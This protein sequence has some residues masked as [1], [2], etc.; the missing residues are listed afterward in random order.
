MIPKFTFR[1]A[2]ILF[3]VTAAF[4]PF[5]RGEAEPAPEPAAATKV[6]SVTTNALAEYKAKEGRGMVALGTSLME[7]KDFKDAE[8]AFRQVLSSRDYQAVHRDAL[9]GIARVY[10]M[11]G[12]LTKAAAIYQKFIKEFSEDPRI[13]DAMLDLGRTLRS[14]GA[15]K[16]AVNSFYNVINSSLK[17]PAD[18]FAHYELLAKTA[19]FEIAETHFEAGNYVDAAKFFSRL[20]LLD[21]APAD[22][23]RAHFKSACALQ[24]QGDLEGAVTTLRAYLEQWPK[25]ENG[26]EARYLLATTLRQLKR[27]DEALAATLDLLRHEQSQS[28]AD[29]KRW[30]YWQRK[31]GNQ[32]ANDFFQDGDS[33][34]AL[35]IYQGL[36]ALAPEPEWRLPLTYQTAL[37]YERLR[38]TDRA[39]KAYQA[40][41]DETASAKAPQIPELTELNHMATWRLAHL[42]WSEQ[43]DHELTTMFATT[44]GQHP[45]A[46][47]PPPPAHDADGSPAASP[48]ALR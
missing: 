42:D 22:R 5:A 43:A 20:R 14:M 45:T 26:P 15:Y 28:E 38:L 36:A 3:L 9:L 46:V 19:Q 17:L 23:A 31:T 40:I 18:G 35:A 34:N 27:T 39:R 37:C 7:R 8:I 41:I 16:M 2:A 48:A 6:E 13:P 10:R 24:L 32:L 47:A 11:N 30:A 44:T 25:D 21:L 4:P 12:E 29:P 1:P 33:I